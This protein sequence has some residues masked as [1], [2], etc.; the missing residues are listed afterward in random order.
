MEPSSF[1]PAPLKGKRPLS[2]AD[3]G[4]NHPP[5]IREARIFPAD[6]SLDSTLAVEVEGEDID[7]DRIAFRYQWVVNGQAFRGATAPQFAVDKLK[8]GDRVT[9]EITPSDGKAN[10]TV[11]Q[12]DAITVGNTAPDIDEIHVEPVPLHRGQTL[13][14]RVIASDP[15]GDPVQL[16]YTWL[17]NDKEIPGARGPS[18]ETKDF[19]KKDVLAVLVIPSDGKAVREGRAGLPVTIKNSP[20]RFTSIPPAES[21]DGQ[22]IYQATVVDPDDDPIT[23]ELKQG[24]PGM[25]I[26]STNGLV[27]WK[28]TPESKGKHHV[29]ILAKDN[30]DGVTKQEFDLE[31]EY[32]TPSPP[33]PPASE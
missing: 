2:D 32:P 5:V 19:H 10:G 7:G 9:L 11:F 33:P 13:K 20:P 18:L 27:S 17:R 16:S 21:K 3:S 23:F 22:Y 28:L 14:T 26:D 30:D 15:D 4:G 1:V 8:Q 31:T 6:P 25:S 29:V 24:P 12:T